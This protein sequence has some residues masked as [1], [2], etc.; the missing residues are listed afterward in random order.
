[1]RV[2]SALLFALL[3]ERAQAFHVMIDPGHGGVD[4]G[5]VHAQ[6]KEA[7]LVLDLAFRLRDLLQ[8]EP[9]LRV[10][11]TRDQ[12]HP[13]TLPERVKKADEQKAD[14]LVSLHANAAPDSK[15]RGLEFFFQNSLPPDEDALY[16][17]NLENQSVSGRE[18]QSPGEISR[19][20]DV[21]AIVEDLHRQSR[22]LS[23]LNFSEILAKQWKGE[24]GKAPSIKQAPFVVVSQ[25]SM[26]SVLVEVGF[27]THP[28][29]AKKLAT[30]SYR[31]DLA[32]KIRDAL[33]DY[34]SRHGS[35]DLGPS[36]SE[37]RP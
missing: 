8:K 14:L 32:R 3:A 11:L 20:G 12:D 4:T 33:V 36:Q 16:L 29:E 22:M 26:P 21:A 6:L 17:A 28:A 9:G 23:S 13:L 30:L 1:M 31:D 7:D 15:A 24:K 27:L 37:T 18:G 5:A 35:R 34:R 10:S 19:R 2:L 25:A